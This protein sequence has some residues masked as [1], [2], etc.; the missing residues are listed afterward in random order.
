MDV[1]FGC[2]FLLYIHIFINEIAMAIQTILPRAVRTTCR[3]D[4]GSQTQTLDR[5]TH[6][7]G[8]EPPNW[9]DGPPM[10]MAPTVPSFR[11]LLCKPLKPSSN[12][13]VLHFLASLDSQS[14]TG[15]CFWIKPRKPSQD[16]D[17]FRVG[18]SA[19]LTAM[20][21]SSSEH[22]SSVYDFS[23]KDIRGED[24]DLSI[25]KGKVM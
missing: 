18:F 15:A 1:C 24:V 5:T 2:F 3:L 12:A 6:R 10:E 21:E 19:N 16:F 23:A 20:T 8:N 9:S 22:N 14:S 11:A 4:G 7:W 13:R 25:Y 17:L